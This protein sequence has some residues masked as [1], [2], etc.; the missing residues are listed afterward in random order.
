MHLPSKEKHKDKSKLILLK[1]YLLIFSKFG[2]ENA[3]IKKICH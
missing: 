1:Q 3:V 2:Y